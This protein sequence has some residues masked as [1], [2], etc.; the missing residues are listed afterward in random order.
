M[1]ISNSY[2]YPALKRIENGNAHSILDMQKKKLCANKFQLT[3]KSD[4]SQ[5]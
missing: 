2:S 3:V 1:T 4:E 5:R